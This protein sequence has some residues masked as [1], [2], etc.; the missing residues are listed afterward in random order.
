VNEAQAFNLA[1]ATIPTMV[2]V[3]IGILLN[4]ARL[5]DVKEAIRAAI[6]VVEAQVK[7]VEAQVQAQGVS[8][9]TLIDK[10]HSEMLHRFGDLD[11]R[12]TRIE[13]S[14]GMSRS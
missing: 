6:K 5:T 4:N 10:N 1:L 8:L 3:L 14:L 11:T 9:G 13:N 12:L 7:T 2:V